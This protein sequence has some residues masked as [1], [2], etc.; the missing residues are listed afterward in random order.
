MKTLIQAIACSLASLTALSQEAVVEGKIKGLPDGTKVYLRAFNAA[1]RGDSAVARGGAFR[2][3]TTV[4]EEDIYLLS[5]GNDRMARHSAVLIY[6]EPGSLKVRGNGPMMKDVKFEGP[7]YAKDLNS[8]AALN[9]TPV[10]EERAALAE[11]MNEAYKIKD[12]LALRALQ[13]DYERLDS[14]IRGVYENWIDGHRAS[15]VSAMALSFFVRYRDMDKLEQRLKTL[16]PSAKE[17]AMARKLQ[18][19]VDAA[20]ATAIGKVAPDFTQNDTLG[21]PVSLR[22]F[23][24]KYVLIDFWASWCVPCRHENPAVV[25]AFQRFKD[26]NFTVLGVSL[27]R[28]GDKDKWIK[29]IHDDNLTWTHVSDLNWWDNAVSRQYDIRSIP[30]NYL[31]DP[32]GRIIGKN[33]RGEALE[34]KLEEVLP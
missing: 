13:P 28:K 4:P 20:K 21:R 26:K 9:S 15:P 3:K 2:I 12:T 23:R 10:F 22:D 5:A 8:L 32:E 7:A 30:A 29:A 18:H 27:D 17:N 31:L 1:G 14:V 19:S 11:K 25:K 6:L 24:G 34:K 33:L 16:A